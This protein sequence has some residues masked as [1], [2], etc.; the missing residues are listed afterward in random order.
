VREQCQNKKTTTTPNKINNTSEQIKMT[1]LSKSGQNCPSHDE[2]IPSVTKL[3]EL[4]QNCQ[5]QEPEAL[6]E[7][8][9]KTSHTYLD[10]K[11]T[12]S[13]QESNDFLDF[14]S[15]EVQ[16][17]P[18]KIIHLETWLASID[19]KTGIKRWEEFY[20][21][22]QETSIARRQEEEQQQRLRNAWSK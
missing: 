16:N 1:D 14:C 8:A 5:N 19:K 9:S 2:I 6:L 21:R 11:N 18:T 13:Y 20:T 15:K 22:Y 12:L 17:Y 3:S 10:F 4:G 7:K